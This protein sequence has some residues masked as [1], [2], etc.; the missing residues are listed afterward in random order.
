MWHRMGDPSLLKGKKLDRGILR[1]AWV[2][3]R[4]FR[5]LIMVFLATI[6]AGA[7]LGLIPPLL[8]RRIID[9][10]IPARNRNMVGAMA[11]LFVVAAVASGSLELVSRSTSCDQRCSTRCSACRSR[12]LREHKQVRSSA[13]SI[14]T[15][16]VRNGP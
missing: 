15:S 5:G 2:F 6:M 10:A 8:F 7:V 14:T 4:P 9:E 3:A 1:R 12:F 11:I 13:A 16:W